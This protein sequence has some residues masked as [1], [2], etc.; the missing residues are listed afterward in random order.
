MIMKKELLSN[1]MINRVFYLSLIGLVGLAVVISFTNRTNAQADLKKMLAGKTWQLKEVKTSDQDL[2]AED[3]DKDEEFALESDLAQIIPNTIVFKADGTCELTY[4]SECQEG[5]VVEDDYSASGKWSVT[6][7]TVK[8]IENVNEDDEMDESHDEVFWLKEVNI[9]RN[10]LKCKFCMQ[11]N[12]T[13]GV[14][15]LVYEIEQ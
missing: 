11:G 6:G 3:F 8:I 14:E 13:A 5:K 2:K 10:E 15:K 4:V 9:T 1:K 7:N 12:Y